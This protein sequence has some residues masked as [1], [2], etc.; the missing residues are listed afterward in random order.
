V[1]FFAFTP[2]FAASPH[3]LCR[4]SHGLVSLCGSRT[5][6]AAGKR[7]DIMRKEDHENQDQVTK[8]SEIDQR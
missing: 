4:P 7:F 1:D 6:K 3:P 8:A 5:A 2:F